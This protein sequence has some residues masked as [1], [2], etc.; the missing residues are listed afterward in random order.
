MFCECP[1]QRVGKSRSLVVC[2]EDSMTFDPLDCRGVFAHNFQDFD[3][4]YRD[5]ISTSPVSQCSPVRSLL[6]VVMREQRDQ[7]RDNW[8][9]SSSVYCVLLNRNP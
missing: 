6:T 5:S 4:G 2:E 7:C 1:G 9:R 3:I 8:R